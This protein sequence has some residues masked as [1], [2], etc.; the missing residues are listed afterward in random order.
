MAARVFRLDGAVAGDQMGYAISG[1]GDINGD[2]LA[3][4]LVASTV[5]D[6]GGVAKGA[7]YVVFGDESGFAA[8]IALD[9]LDGTNGFRIAGLAGSDQFAVSVSG[10]GDFNGDGLADLVIGASGFTGGGAASGASYVVYGKNTFAADVDVS[11]LAAASSGLRLDGV[12]AGDN[13]GISVSAA[14]DVNGD[15]FRRSDHR[16]QQCRQRWR[17]QR[18]ELRG[19]RCRFWLHRYREPRR[20]DG[21]QRFPHRWHRRLPRQ[22]RGGERRRRSERRRF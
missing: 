22:R 16:R 19:V 4:V 6:V 3:D 12:A 2:G 21:P 10:A 11:T 20:S 1:I 18:L 8:S 7:A 9:T 13:A 15:G 14:G 17:G 5:A